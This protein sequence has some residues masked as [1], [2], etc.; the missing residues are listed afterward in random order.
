MSPLPTPSRQ[1]LRQL[2]TL[3]SAAVIGGAA[4]IAV[5]G[6]ATEPKAT[7]ATPALP[8]V[9]VAEVRSQTVSN[10]QFYAA[11]AA[12]AKHVEVR[13]RVPGILLKRFYTEGE[14]VERG[15]TLF[16]IDPTQF[17]V[18]V[19]RAKAELAS[20]TAKL[21]KAERDW[22]RISS[23]FGSGA[24][25]A[26]QRDDTRSALELAG[27]EVAMAKAALDQT[28]IQLDYTAV[29]API[30]GITSLQAQDPGNLVQDQTL[31]TTITEL[32]PI[33]VQFSLPETEALAL[34]R[35]LRS[36]VPTAVLRLADGDA[37]PIEGTVD[38]A[39]SSIDPK[40]GTVQARAVFPN[41]RHELMPGQ[42]VRITLP[43]LQAG[44]A[45]VVPQQAVT[46][47]ADGPVVYVVGADRVAEPRPVEL[48][49]SVGGD[50][51]IR[52]GLRDGELIVVDG[53]AGVRPGSK[54]EVVAT[55]AVLDA[56]ASD[57]ATRQSAAVAGGV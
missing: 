10:E 21:N 45:L 40:T 26:G 44:T 31:L 14:L 6:A 4:L 5:A 56:T 15:A 16:Q 52:A 48:G 20:A 3:L 50:L 30:R 8:R 24:I 22:R 25:S 43:Q 35:Q 23:L 38:F 28:R 18:Q 36:G 37:Y 34:R 9:S 53:L 54:V 12:G 47:S 27:A 51:V 1:R 46:Q 49:H 55:P 13:A 42:F 32:D 11:R 33:H 19:Q 2:R 7:A 41:P 29:T 39:E 17:Q 57:N